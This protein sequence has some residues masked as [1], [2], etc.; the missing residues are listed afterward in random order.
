MGVS[1]SA[2]SVPPAIPSLSSRAEPSASTSS[3]NRPSRVPRTP[4]LERKILLSLVILSALSALALLL[5]FWPWLVLA[6]WTGSL[7][8]PLLQRLTRAIHGRRGAA[9]V[10]TLGLLVVAFTP[11]VV[12][13]ASVA[14]DVYDLAQR[15]LASDSGRGALVELVTTSSEGNGATTTHLEWEKLMELL[16]A[17]GQE[18]WSVASL[19]ASALGT[20]GLGILVFFA[21]TYACMVHGPEAYQWLQRQIPLAPERIDRVRDAFQ[22]TGRGLLY[23]VALTGLLQAALATLG[24]ALLGV[25]R[26]LALGLATFLTSLIPAIGPFLVWGPVAV[27]LWLA[28]Q[29]TKAAILAALCTIIVAPADN[30]LRP[31]L[32][33]RGSLQLHPWLVFFSMLGGVVTIG[34]WGIMLGPLVFRLAFEFADLAREARREFAASAR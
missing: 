11:L 4:Q 3:E 31:M 10:L 9:G 6:L 30:F 18:A 29:G 34:G 26:A 14:P 8:R 17:H 33:R 24:Y 22:E 23:S 32:A 19:L 16:R 2:F 20:A 28:G 13:I 15:A 1:K 27:G 25:P 21:A 7:A 12:G 5:P